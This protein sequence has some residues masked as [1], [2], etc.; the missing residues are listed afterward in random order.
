MYSYQEALDYLY[1]FVNFETRPPQSTNAFNL[2]RVVRLLHLLGDPHHQFR[3]V[4]IAGTKGKGSTTAMIE[5][6]LRRAGY[7]TGLFTSPHLHTFRE[8]IRIGGEMI[9]S[10]QFVAEVARI[11]PFAEQVPD[12]TTFEVTTALAFSHFAREKIDIAVVEVGLGGRLDATNVLTP[13][14]SVIT[15]IGYDHTTI[16]GR[17]LGQIAGEKAGIIKPGRPIVI[18]PQR[19]AALQVIRSVARE[20]ESA[21]TLVEGEWQWKKKWGDPTGQSFALR[22][23]WELPG[24][25]I[26]LLG[27]HQLQN[28]ATA[29]ATV[30]ILARQGLAIS[31]EHIGEGLA[32]V[33]WPGRLEVLSRNPPLI[34][35]GAHN[36]DAARAITTAL[37][38]EFPGRRLIAV[39]GFS[40]DK[41]IRGILRLLLPPARRIILTQA[42]HPRAAGV[43][44][45]QEQV[46]SLGFSSELVPYVP[47]AVE[48]AQSLAEERDL[49]L[50]TGSLFVAAEARAYWLKK[51]GF[52]LE[53]DPPIA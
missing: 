38:E 31:P 24:L 16:L 15:P 34:V 21:L 51:S 50:V 43:D 4:H 17:R 6:V 3:S 5:S 19:P 9:S 32:R 41:D 27:Q 18:A 14:V 8:R 7:R 36:V 20:R 45:L 28:A 44:S 10:P 12:L 46:E 23:S 22:N 49:I 1:R 48:H 33:S 35:D 47:Q 11:K 29:V 39:L 13:L 52:P 25:W 37:A 42:R 30:S 40:G 53:E 2:G 26:P